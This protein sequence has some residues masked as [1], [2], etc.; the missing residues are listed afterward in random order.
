MKSPYVRAYEAGI[1]LAQ[2]EW[3]EKRAKDSRLNDRGIEDKTPEDLPER[4]DLMR[5][6]V[7]QRPSHRWFGDTP[8]RYG[9][10]VYAKWGKS[11]FYHPG[12]P[13]SEVSEDGPLEN[14]SSQST[15]RIFV[16][17]GYYPGG[18]RKNTKAEGRRVDKSRRAGYVNPIILGHE[19]SH[20]YGA[21][22]VEADAHGAMTNYDLYDVADFYN[23][24]AGR[25]DKIDGPW[26]TDPHLND[27][28]RLDLFHSMLGM[29]P[30]KGP[31]P[32][33]KQ[34]PPVEGRGSAPAAPASL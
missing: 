5:D 28:E 16:G 32:L 8:F 21:D 3:N 12:R 13:A 30:G 33:V 29:E 24:I 10:A 11:P 31:R 9:N 34:F 20:S 19:A 25:R 23:T 15:P 7:E 2:L 26:E 17:K 6:I 4:V 22:E 18:G 14:D 1:K 27:F